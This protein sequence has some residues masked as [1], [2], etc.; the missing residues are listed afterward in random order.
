ME[1][2]VIK[3]TWSNH[4]IRDWAEPSCF[5]SV[6]RDLPFSSCRVQME[7]L[8]IHIKMLH[9]HI[10]TCISHT[11]LVFV[12]APGHR[13]G[14]GF[15]LILVTWVKSSLHGLG[16]KIQ[17]TELGGCPIDVTYTRARWVFWNGEKL[18]NGSRRVQVGQ[19]R[20]YSLVIS[21]L[22]KFSNTGQV[23]N[24]DIGSN[25]DEPTWL[26]PVPNKCLIWNPVIQE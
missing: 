7:T 11:F 5:V 1:F 24:C 21:V 20:S 4:S 17:S 2:T 15:S 14:S 16:S 3:L 26:R 10:K 12:V 6:A 13:L 9:E 23:L 19:I 22:C 25:S 8:K 18:W